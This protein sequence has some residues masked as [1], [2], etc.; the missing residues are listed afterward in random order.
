MLSAEHRT[1][2][3]CDML[4][5][6]VPSSTMTFCHPVCDTHKSQT[7][8]WHN[9]PQTRLY[10]CNTK[11]V[12]TGDDWGWLHQSVDRQRAG[13]HSVGPTCAVREL[14]L[15]ARPLNCAVM[16]ASCTRKVLDMKQLECSVLLSVNNCGE[17]AVLCQQIC[18]LAPDT[19]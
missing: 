9:E 2:R 12:Y 17:M 13:L 11:T 1:P 16:R 18:R 3:G 6:R 15:R 10:T 7:L 4:L 14:M 8:W 5:N 19:E